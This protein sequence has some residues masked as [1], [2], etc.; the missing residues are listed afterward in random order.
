MATKADGQNGHAPPPSS[1]AE[2][3]ACIDHTLLRPEATPADIER[4]CAQAVRY[5][6]KAVC[7]NPWHLPLA[8]RCLRGSTPLPIT[9]SGFPL[10]A[11]QTLCKAREAGLAVEQGAAEV[12]MVLNVGALKAGDLS[13]V[14]QDILEVVQACGPV[15][16][17]VI[18]ETCLL[19]DAEKELAC[20]LAVDAGARFVKTSTGFSSGGAT[21]ADVRLLRRAVDQAAKQAGAPRLGVKASGGI[22]TL[23]D[24]LRLLFAGADRL[25]A[26]ASVQ[27]VLEMTKEC[28]A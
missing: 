16:V 21:E 11:S 4:L 1:Q 28:G 18:L 9:V 20:R 19:T 26:S 7:V 13:L 22:K 6:F 25:G 3:A 8:V 5:G 15:P 17:K 24:A 12:D 10:G 2:L 27:M 14:R 23:D